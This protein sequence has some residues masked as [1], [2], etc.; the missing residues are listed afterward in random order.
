MFDSLF[1]DAEIVSIAKRKP[2]ITHQPHVHFE[3]TERFE[4]WVIFFTMLNTSLL[5]GVFKDADFKYD[6]VLAS[7][8]LLCLNAL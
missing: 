1:D 5:L 2:M 3:Y 4:D 8:L 6:T 7:T